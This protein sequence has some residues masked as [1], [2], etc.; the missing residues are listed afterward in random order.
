VDNIQKETDSI[1]KAI[2]YIQKSNESISKEILKS[3]NLQNFDN[4]SSNNFN[5]NP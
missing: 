4:N 2:N 3:N 1:S 5:N